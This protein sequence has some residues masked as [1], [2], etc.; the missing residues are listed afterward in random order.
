M[1]FA[2][3]HLAFEAQPWRLLSHD[4]Y[5]TGIKVKFLAEDRGTKQVIQ[6][7]P[8]IGYTVANPGFRSRGFLLGAFAILSREFRCYDLRVIECSDDIPVGW[9]NEC[10]GTWTAVDC[11]RCYEKR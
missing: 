8:Y 7:K 4:F 9:L 11:L 5:L 2:A 3:P 6:E 1:A 10:R